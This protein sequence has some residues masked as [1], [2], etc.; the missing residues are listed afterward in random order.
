MQQAFHDL[1][2][3]LIISV[4]EESRVGLCS[5]LKIKLNVSHLH[6]Y[7]T[8]K[9][10]A[11]P[12]TVSAAKVPPMIPPLSDGGPSGSRSSSFL[13]SEGVRVGVGVGVGVCV[14]SGKLLTQPSEVNVAQVP[15]KKFEQSQRIAKEDCVN[16]SS[17][18]LLQSSDCSRSA[19][20]L[21]VRCQ[22]RHPQYSF[23]NEPPA[24]Q[25][26]IR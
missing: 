13:G 5:T 16:D 4:W 3:F 8:R 26:A 14:G 9:N 18:Q 17:V 19:S 7:F 2:A 25:S 23:V 21:E 11:V 12:N 6:R 24:A 20:S 1:T 15:I 22:I 10:E